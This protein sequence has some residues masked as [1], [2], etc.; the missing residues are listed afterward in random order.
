[1]E[2]FDWIRQWWNVLT[3]IG[4]VA[5]GI[6]MMWLRSAF[7]PKTD[8]DALKVKVDGL[9]VKLQAV[10][11]AISH[12]PSKDS[13]HQM[14]LAIAKIEANFSGL[15]KQITAV[16]DVARRVEGYLLERPQ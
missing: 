1:M 11:V 13:F 2:N 5:L 10:D 8:H 3:T 6:G 12:L 16:G 7:T 4:V 15:E 14:A 9:D